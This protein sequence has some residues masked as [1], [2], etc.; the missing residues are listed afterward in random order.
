MTT[1][2]PRTRGALAAVAA[3]TLG[4]SACALLFAKDAFFFGYLSAFEL[5]LGVPAGCIALLM[6]HHLS[7]GRWSRAIR[8]GAEVGALTV[9]LLAALFLPVAA[10]LGSLYIW[11]HDSAVQASAELTH[12]APYLDVPFF[13]GRAVAF[14]AV[15][16]ALALLLLRWSRR[17]DPRL[18]RLSGGGLVLH[19]L[20]GTF[21]AIDWFGSLDPTWYSTVFGLYILVG[22]G[23]TA[24]AVLVALRVASRGADG[25]GRGTLGDLGNLI[26][27]FVI[28]HAY[29][30]YSQF[31]IIW[32][33]DKPH[34]IEWYLP[35]IHGAWGAVAIL[36]L[37]LHF[38]L[39]FALLLFRAVKRRPGTLLL[40]CALVLAGRVADALWII[41]PAL[42]NA[43][44]LAVGVALAATVGM[45]AL[46]LLVFSALSARYWPS[47]QGADA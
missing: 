33:G 4:A 3:A 24:L 27:T 5:W 7:G 20:V 34:E 41:L 43:Q 2:P 22:Q 29:L 42:P 18:F 13:L 32:N 36:L 6:T 1:L 44:L 21:A 45:G 11:T 37:L 26:L 14:F 25:I 19:F 17:R 10:G 16:G 8:P 28:L 40:V 9:A 35:R 38:V 12:K 46:W 15:W 30:A 47:A 39:P 23:L 31:F